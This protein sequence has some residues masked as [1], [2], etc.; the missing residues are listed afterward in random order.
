[1]K[2]FFL[3]YNI[4]EVIILL[5]LIFKINL[6]IKINKIYLFIILEDNIMLFVL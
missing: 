5:L 1:M 4:Y 3:C 6:K 2:E